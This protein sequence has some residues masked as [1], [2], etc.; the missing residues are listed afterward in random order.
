MELRSRE[1][2]V[3]ASD[4]GSLVAWY[5]A[6]L[7]FE[8]V[9]RF[10]DGY[11]SCTLRTPSGVVIGIASASEMGVSPTDRAHNTVVLHLEVDDVAGFL[12]H[13][14]EAGGTVTGGPSLDKHDGFWFGSFAD[15]EGNPFWVVDANCP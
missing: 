14:G 11:H 1:P 7:G 13:V 8:E 4:F 2:I 15:P 10:E 3:L 9:A 6:A 12:A 5:R